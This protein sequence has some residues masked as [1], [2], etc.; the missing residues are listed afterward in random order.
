MYASVSAAVSNIVLNSIF[1][2]IYGFTAAGY[3]TMISYFVQAVIDYF[4]MK[5]VV[6][7]AIYNMKYIGLLSIVVIGVSLF[8]VVLYHNTLVRYGLIALVVAV[9]FYFR[10]ALI[11][12][13]KLYLDKAVD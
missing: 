4:A 6:G 11:K 1:I 8:S 7:I 2:P 9:V 5:N 12:M 10:R 13:I 3:T